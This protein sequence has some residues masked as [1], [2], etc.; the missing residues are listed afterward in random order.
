MTVSS[1]D[2]FGH[3]VSTGLDGIVIE[4]SDHFESLGLVNADDA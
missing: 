4:K 3:L 1:L 2:F